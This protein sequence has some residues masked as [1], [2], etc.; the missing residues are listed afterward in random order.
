[1]IEEITLTIGTLM[2]EEGNTHRKVDAMS[3][4]TTRL[5][6]NESNCRFISI[7]TQ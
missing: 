6:E 2:C 1:M 5:I 7:L 4:D 3:T